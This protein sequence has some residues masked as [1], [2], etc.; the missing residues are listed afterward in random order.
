MCCDDITKVVMGGG[1]NIFKVTGSI[2]KYIQSIITDD[3]DK[4][5]VNSINRQGVFEILE[6]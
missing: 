5:F 3:V 6:T 1:L 2:N 4:G